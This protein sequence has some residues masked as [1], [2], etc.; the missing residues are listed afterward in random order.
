METKLRCFQYVSI[1]PAGDRP[2]KHQKQMMIKF[3]CNLTYTYATFAFY[4]Q[5]TH[6]IVYTCSSDLCTLNLVN[7]VHDFFSRFKNRRLNYWKILHTVFF[8]MNNITFFS[9]FEW[10]R[11][12]CDWCYEIIWLDVH[13]IGCRNSASFV[14][15]E[16]A[17]HV[18]IH[19][20]IEIHIE[21]LY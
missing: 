15:C 5:D 1:Q 3:N 7:G 12:L 2:T 4:V 19:S 13:V 17:V 18:D 21:R 14:R 16:I 11:V 20:K 9:F 8:C 10:E 6:L